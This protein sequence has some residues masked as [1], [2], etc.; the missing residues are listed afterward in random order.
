MRPIR[1][2][3]VLAAVSLTTDLASGVPFEKGLRTCALAGAFGVAL[4]LDE[5]ERTA[6]FHASLLRAVGCTS[7]A[8]EN[9]AL[10]GNDMAFQAALKPMDVGDPD[11][12]GA[13]LA[14]FGA[15][16]G[17]RRPAGTGPPL[18]RRRPRRGSARDPCGV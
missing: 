11:V 5:A 8:S 3:E 9:A 13:Q 10:F 17:A 4:G 16:A 12:F 2:A 18:R 1:V 15:W 7:Q 6:L 14:G